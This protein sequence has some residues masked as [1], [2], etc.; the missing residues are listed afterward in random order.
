MNALDFGE[1]GSSSQFSVL[2]CQSSV[3]SVPSRVLT[4]SVADLDQLAR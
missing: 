4:R 3:V 1:Q 2:S